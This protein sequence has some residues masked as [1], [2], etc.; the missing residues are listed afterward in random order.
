[1]TKNPSTR[2]IRELLTRN[3]VTVNA[4]DTLHEALELMSE[5]RVTALPVINHKG[6][7]S[8]I[9]SAFDLV[10]LTRELDDELSDLGWVEDVS[11]Q[12]I[13]DRLDK[14]DLTSRQVGE[15][16]T[17]EVA[18]V[19]ADMTVLEAAREMLKNKVHRLPVVE[20]PS[21]LL[22][23]V[24]TMDLLNGFVEAAAE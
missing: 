3:P 9:V 7:C 5:N 12:W 17:V 19:T 13:L 15:I 23:I 24:S 8:G 18:T 16:M 2:R 11:H 4:E 20:K 22:G 10:E 14:H 1:M 21:R 6:H